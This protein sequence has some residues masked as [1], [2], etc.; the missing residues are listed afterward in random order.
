M[1]P[2]VLLYLPANPVHSL[3][4]VF[5]RLTVGNVPNLLRFETKFFQLMVHV[6]IE[7]EGKVHVILQS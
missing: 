3:R 5:S 1:F 7:H 6:S 2:I 4:T